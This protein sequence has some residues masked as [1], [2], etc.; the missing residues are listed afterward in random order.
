[1]KKGIAG[2]VIVGCALCGLAGEAQDAFHRTV[3]QKYFDEDMKFKTAMYEKY[4][5][6][7]QA[8][9]ITQMKFLTI[10]SNLDILIGTD[11]AI[12]QQELGFLNREG[13]AKE[14]PDYTFDNVDSA[15][16]IRQLVQLRDAWKR[17]KFAD[18]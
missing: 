13:K 12:M 9:Q 2:A 14:D 10:F 16:Q 11:A 18:L 3:G 7:L 6:K 15:Y 17:T 8:H 4:S 5:D 1:V